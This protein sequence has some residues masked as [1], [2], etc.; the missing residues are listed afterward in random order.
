MKRTIIAISTIGLLA[1]SALAPAQAYPAGSAPTIGLSEVSRL[2]PGSQVSVQISRVKPGCE[3]SVSWIGDD[4][5][6]PAA[7][8]TVKGTGK[9]GIIRINTPSTAGD[10]TLS[11]LISPTCAGTASNVVLEKTIIV[12]KMA[13]I[14]GKLSTTS[15]FISKTPTLSLTGTVKSGSVAVAN[16]AVTVVLKKN[17]SPVSTK[18]AT[19]SGTGTLSVSFAGLNLTA[20]D[21]RASIEVKAGSTYYSSLVTTSKITLR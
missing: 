15:G 17:G 9:S 18:L 14:V 21:Y 3:V 7:K 4:I 12:G 8:A 1:I 19:T 13:S 16:Q 10:Y 2:I 6:I 11:T 20:G 5:E